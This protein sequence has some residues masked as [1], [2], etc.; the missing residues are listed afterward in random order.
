MCGLNDYRPD[1]LVP[2]E[3]NQYVPW[4]RVFHDGWLRNRVLDSFNSLFQVNGDNECKKSWKWENSIEEKRRKVGRD[5]FE[6]FIL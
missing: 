2:S 1:L 4:G 3:V 6:S 5:I